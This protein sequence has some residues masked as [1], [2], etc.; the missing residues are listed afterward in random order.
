MRLRSPPRIDNFIQFTL[1]EFLADEKSRDET[2]HDILREWPVN[3][4]RRRKF[5]HYALKRAGEVVESKPDYHNIV[6]LE[7]HAIALHKHV[8]DE[9]NIMNLIIQRSME[10]NKDGMVPALDLSIESLETKILVDDHGTCSICLEEFSVDGVSEV[11]KQ[12]SSMTVSGDGKVEVA[13]NRFGGMGG[14][15]WSCI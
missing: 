8:F 12:V 4:A 14:R 10:G 1:Q 2:I 13:T 5:I 6:H 15:E 9:R 7:F 11:V 3:N